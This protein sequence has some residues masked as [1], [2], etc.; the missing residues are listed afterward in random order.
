MKPQAHKNFR[1]HG[2][3]P[4]ISYKP[5]HMIWKMPTGEAY[6]IKVDIK[7]QPGEKDSETLAIYMPLFRTISHEYP[8]KLITIL[9]RIIKGHDLSTGPQK[10]RMTRNL[11]IREYIQVFEQKTKYRGTDTN[12][13]YE[14]AMKDIITHFFPPKTL[15]CQKSFLHR[16]FYKPCN[17]KIREFIYSI[18]EI[19]EYLKKFPTF[20]TNQGLPEYD[21]L[22]LVDFLLPIEWQTELLIQRLDSAT[23]GLTELIE[24]CERL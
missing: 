4:P 7:T 14:L 24:L 21:I 18:D 13:K 20:G 12:E 19:I 5:N 9:N 17:N 8:H 15:Q 22:Y 6:S 11:V 2:P 23:Q 3:H 1:T 16:G 10:Y